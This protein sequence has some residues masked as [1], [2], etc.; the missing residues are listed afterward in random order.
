[1]VL[2]NLKKIML[3][4]HLILIVTF[5]FI[6]CS[7][8]SYECHSHL[9]PHHVH[10]SHISSHLIISC[11]CISSSSSLLLTCIIIHRILIFS[12][13]TLTHTLISPVKTWMTH[14][15]NTKKTTTFICFTLSR[16]RWPEISLEQA[17]KKTICNY[18]IKMVSSMVII[19]RVILHLWGGRLKIR[20]RVELA[21]EEDA[22]PF[23]DIPKLFNIQSY[24]N[25]SLR[26]HLT[27]TSTRRNTITPNHYSNRYSIQYPKSYLT[28]NKKL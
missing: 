6:K 15:R 26:I 21:C 7:P 8:L 28:N 10:S 24:L 25:I 19:Q 20:T 11:H 1:M 5:I 16:I 27:T 18:I 3:R 12:P 23:Q 14:F 17:E 13:L 22:P 2:I 9:H 4:T